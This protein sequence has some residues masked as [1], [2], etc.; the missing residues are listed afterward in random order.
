MWFWDLN[1]CF[2]SPSNCILYRQSIWTIAYFCTAAILLFHFILGIYFIQSSKSEFDG[3][4]H[5]FETCSLEIMNEESHICIHEIHWFNECSM[6][7]RM[8]FKKKIWPKTEPSHVFISS[9]IEE[10]NMNL[11]EKWKRPMPKLYLFWI[12]I[13]D[14]QIQCT[15]S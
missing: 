14:M 12:L 11:N 3:E 7:K 5:V 9:S 13:W 15:R 10:P 6:K 4:R 2:M 1:N 8:K